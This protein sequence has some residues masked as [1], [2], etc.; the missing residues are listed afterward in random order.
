[1]SNLLLQ[2]HHKGTGTQREDSL[3]S[4]AIVAKKLFVTRQKFGFGVEDFERHLLFSGFVELYRRDSK[5]KR[6]ATTKKK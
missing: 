6:K 3:C 5:E 1:M 2:F 4:C